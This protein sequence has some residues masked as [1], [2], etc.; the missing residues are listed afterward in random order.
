MVDDLLWPLDEAAFHDC[1][2]LFL[3]AHDCAQAYSLGITALLYINQWGRRYLQK[4][5]CGL[6]S[7]CVFLVSQGGITATTRLGETSTKHSPLG[8][9]YTF[10]THLLSL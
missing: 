8:F 5:F 6:F 7:Y 4:V 10:H 2:N 9:N 3:I 1:I